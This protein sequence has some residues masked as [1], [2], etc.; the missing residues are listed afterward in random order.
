MPL[1]I[2]HLTGCAPAPL[3]HY[4]KALGILR[5]VAEQKDPS[6]RG[7][8]KDE[9]FHLATTLDRNELE[10]FFLDEYRP[11]PMF[12]PWGARSGYYAGSSEKSSRSALE[13]I[14]QSQDKRFESFQTAIS[15]IRSILTEQFGGK[16]PEEDTEKER[17]VRLV[18]QSVDSASS[19]WMDTCVTCLSNGTAHPAIFGTGASEGSG[20]YMSAYMLALQEAVI[21]RSYD[22]GLKAALWGNAIPATTW[23]ETFGHFLPVGIG[24]PWELLLSF[25]GI[26]LVRS[27]VTSTSKPQSSKWMSSPFFVA[28]IA[29]AYGSASAQDE[30]A[31]NKGKKMPGRGEQW[32]PLWD[33]PLQNGEIRTVFGQGRASIKRGTARNAVSMTVAIANLGVQRGISR[34]VRFG[35]QQRNNLATH[36]AVPLGQFSVPDRSATG[37]ELIYEV[38]PWI[39]RLRNILRTAKNP[40]SSLLRAVRNVDGILMSLCERF[41]LKTSWQALLLALAEIEEQMVR[42]HTFTAKQRLKPIPPLSGAWIEATNDRSSEFQLAVALALQCGDTEGRNHIRQHWL[43]LDKTNKTGPAFAADSNGLRKDPEVVCH[44]LEPER[45]LLSLLQRRSIRS[46]K[47]LPLVGHPHF[48]ASP[49]DIGALLNGSVDLRKTMQLAR[50]LLAL[51]RRNLGTSR[52]ESNSTSLPA[53]YALFRLVTLPWPLEIKGST[54][55]IRFDPAILSRLVSGG[56]DSLRVAGE[57]AIRRLKAAKLTPVLRHIA[58]D[59][60]LALRIAVSLAFPISHD[61]AVHLKHALTKPQPKQT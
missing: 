53:I 56:S 50:A 21:K 25:E 54:I 52:L 22:E 27:A 2:H 36:F 32:F 24:G 61:T 37:A 49:S 30:I 55:P 59:D 42:S 58:G 13:Q 34:F 5:L 26:C 20:S 19:A 51:D 9:A 45:D 18:R 12:N 35:Y 8:W 48:F 16:K 46:D 43:P 15:T 3:A 1:H 29:A 11:T 38:L 17:L 33:R 44:G 14:E 60:K 47:H 23:S 4:L 39:E 41:H 6:A 40:P 57:M 7:W 10:R 31:V 28:P